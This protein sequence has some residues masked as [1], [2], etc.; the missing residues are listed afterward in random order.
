VA[1]KAVGERALAEGGVLAVKQSGEKATGKANP[2]PLF[3]A[4]YEAPPKNADFLDGA[5]QGDPWATTGGDSAPAA[6]A[7]AAD[8]EPPF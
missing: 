3:E 4:R 1:V 5:D 7:P 8:D 6:A 2:L